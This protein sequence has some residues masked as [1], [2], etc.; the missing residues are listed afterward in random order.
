MK[1]T[2]TDVK[3]QDGRYGK[4][5]ALEG[6]TDI[7]ATQLRLLPPS[8]KIL[9]ILSMPEIVMDK[10][11]FDARLY[12]R[13]FHLAFTSR[14]ERARSFLRSRTQAHRDLCS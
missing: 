2:Q 10:Q 12:V 11:D 9:V 5:I 8:Q 7:L 3:E 4:L 14:T 13:Q 1:A 6:D